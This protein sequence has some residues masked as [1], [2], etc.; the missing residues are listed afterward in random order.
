MPSEQKTRLLPT[1]AQDQEDGDSEA[2][3][4]KEPIQ[5]EQAIEEF[6]GDKDLL[7]HLIAG[8][9]ENLRKQIPALSRAL[10]KGDAREMLFIAHRIKG[11]AANLTAYPLSAAA[12]KLE[13]LS[14]SGKLEGAAPLI[15][16]IKKEIK[17]LRDFLTKYI[18]L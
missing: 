1:A 13:A 16:N 4:G 2:E 9:L 10:K 18:Q 8:F 3:P 5:Y 12:A 6:D 17:R 14:E 11:G 15:K 7:D